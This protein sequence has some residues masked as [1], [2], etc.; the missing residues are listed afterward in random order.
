MDIRDVEDLYPVSYTQQAMLM[1]VENAPES[2]A[3]TGLL[4]C[5]MHAAID[6]AAFGSAWQQVIDKHAILRTS[7]IWKGVEQPIQIVQRRVKGTLDQIDL[8]HLTSHEQATQLDISI[9]EKREK[10]INATAPPLIRLVLFRTGEAAYELAWSYHRLVLDERSLFVILKEVSALYAGIPI[11]HE[12][13]RPYSDYIAWLKQQDSS[14]AGEYWRRVLEGFSSPTALENIAAFANLEKQDDGM[15]EQSLKLSRPASDLLASSARKFR[16]NS[17]TVLQGVWALLL[18]RYSGQRDVIYGATVSTSSTAQ[19]EGPFL[20]GPYSNTLPMRVR[21][22]PEAP[23]LA[24]LKSLQEQQDELRQYSFTSPQKVVPSSRGSHHLPL[25]ESR[26]VLDDFSLNGS[27]QSQ[28]GTLEIRGIRLYEPLASPLTLR[29]IEG[30]EFA[31]QINYDHRR[32]DDVTVSRLLRHLQCL[33]EGLAVQ[34]DANLSALGILREQEVRQVLIDWNNTQRAYTRDASIQHLFEGQV[35]QT[36][37][38]VAL[39]L[40]DQ[41]LSY[42]ELNRRANQLANHLRTLGIGPDVAVG[43]CIGV[44]FEMIISLQAILKAGGAYVP[45]DPSYP[46]DRLAFILDDIQAPVILTEGRFSEELPVG[47]AQVICLDSDWEEMTS[48]SG[49]NLPDRAGADNVAYMMYTSGSTGLPKGVSVIHRG[50]VR[51]IKETNYVDLNAEEVLLQLAPITFDASTFEIWGSLLNGGRLALMPVQLPSLEEIEEAIRRYEVTTMWLTAGLFHL[52]VD[53]RVEVLKPLRQ[54]LAGGDVLSVQHVLKVLQEVPGCRLINGYGPTESTTFTCCYSMAQAADVTSSVPIGRPISNTEVYLL[55]RDFQPAPV[56][57][58]GELFIGGDGLARCYHNRPELTAE[59]FV[60]NPFGEEP[61]ERLYRTGD[62]ARY[63]PD[64]I[65]EFLGRMDNQVKIR[66]FRVEPGE[67][68]AAL[69]GHPALREA[70]VVARQD[71]RG[72]KRLVG[73]FVLHE[74]QECAI[75]E[76]RRYVKERLPDYMVPAAFVKLDALPLNPNGKVDR[77]GLPSPHQELEDSFI[78]PRTLIEEILAEIWI[79]VLGIE[80][81]GIHDSFFDLGGDSIRSIQVRARAQ[82]RGLDFS[83]QQL[84]E[85]QTIYE[86]AQEVRIVDSN[87]LPAQEA[88]PFSLIPEGES[89]QLGY[90]VEDAYPM[91]LLQAG[92]LFHSELSP[93][94]AVYHDIFSF[95]IQ[96]PLDLPSLRASI[97]RLMGEH[98][99]LRT[100]FDQTSFSAPMQ[101][102]HRAVDIPLHVTDLTTL[103]ADEQEEALAQWLT[104]ESNNHFDPSKAPLLRFYAH[105]RSEN[106]F[107]FGVS[108]HH[109]ILDGW[110]FASMMTELFDLYTSLIR[111]ESLPALLPPKATFQQYV[112]LEQAS[113]A[114]QECKLFWSERLSDYVVTKLPRWPS[115]YRIKNDPPVLAQN[116]PISPDISEGLKQLARSAGVPLKS[117]LLACHLRVLSLL[118]GTRDV[119]TGTVTNGRPEGVDGERVLGLFLNTL[120]F[121]LHLPRGS[122]LDLVKETFRAELETIPFRHYPLA[123]IQVNQGRQSLF[124]TAFNF[125][126]FHVYKKI[127][128]SDDLNVIGG[129][130]MGETNLT[131]WA[132]FSLDLVS[133]EV[134]LELTGAAAE[135]S[136]EQLMLIGGYYERA[137]AA[138]AEDPTANYEAVNL[139]SEWERQQVIEE[140]NDTRREFVGEGLGDEFEEQAAGTGDRIAVVYEEE[141]VSYGELN[142]RGNRLGRYLRGMGVVED[143]GVGVCMRRGVEMVAAVV[144]VLKSGGAYVPLD[145]GYPRERLRY[146][147]EDSGA[148]VV[149]S[150]QEE[151]GVL[152][153]VREVRIGEAGVREEIRSQAEWNLGRLGSGESLG[154]IIYTSGSTGRPKGIGLPR[155]ALRNLIGWHYEVL[156]RE[157]RTLQFASLSFDVSFYEIF[158]A[159][160]SGGTVYVVE[161]EVRRDVERLMK[162]VREREVEKVVTPV[163]VLQQMGENYRGQEKEYET[164]K[165]VI[166]TGE[167]LQISRGVREMFREMRGV[168]LQNHYGPSE[169]HVVT[170]EEMS[171]ES[172]GWEVW[173]LIGRP[174]SNSEIYVV[175]GSLREVGIGREG[176]VLIGGEGVARGYI[177]RAEM[178]AEKFIPDGSGKRVG[179]RVYRSGDE[180]RYEGDGKIR[181]LGRR[182]KQVKVR[183]FRVEL[184]EVESVLGEVGGVREAVVEARENGRGEKQ[185]VGYI[186]KG[187]G[188]RTE[189]EIREEMSRKLPDYMVPAVLIEMEKLP[190]TTN[191]KVDRRALPDPEI[192]WRSDTFVSPR[193]AAEK[194]VADVW[195]AVLG[196]ERVGIHDNF[197]VL[198]GHSLVATQVM[199]R[200]RTAFQIDIPL[201]TLFEWP[202]VAGLAQTIEKAIQGGQG[203]SS[204]AV[205]PL[206]LIQP[207][208]TRRPFFCVHPAGGTVF[209]YADLA[210]QLG[211]ERPFYGIQAH[212]FEDQPLPLTRIE[213]MSAE[214]LDCL[215]AAQPEG[216]YFIGGWS[217]GGIVA[218]DMARRLR[219]QG[220]EIKLLALFDTMPPTTA[221]SFVEGEYESLLVEFC[222]DIG[223]DDFMLEWQEL[224]GLKPDQQLALIL[225]RAKKA[226]IVP[227]DVRLSQVWRLFDV[228]KTNVNAMLNYTPQ[229]DYARVTLFRASEGIEQLRQKGVLPVGQHASPLSADSASVIPTRDVDWG[230]NEFVK[231]GPEL[232]IVPGNHYT[233]LKSPHLQTLA[234]KLSQCISEAEDE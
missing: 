135:L 16:L 72:E 127:Q 94:T 182:D 80:R 230:W 217:M 48:C 191:G 162:Y 184:G 218:F 71:E 157:A 130:G 78:A 178:T 120:P 155:K 224:A 181:Y 168:R 214:Y 82:Q 212:I 164:L 145:P 19:A 207:L 15:G 77:L 227:P 147:V 124:E 92:M 74:Q 69:S 226:N 170:W 228:F 86:L 46:L 195:C 171:G 149:I 41:Q 25:Y 133:S 137:L 161:Q 38:A 166:S 200:V 64:G 205:S 197:F 35:E 126:H 104:I 114:S 156:G 23:A 111:N 7:F 85:H 187:G 17:K 3:H 233:M 47:Q 118:S 60:P 121:R 36:P 185:L 231:S 87:T 193:T 222:R 75:D 8:R 30:Q 28:N 31:V 232:H 54:L 221:R 234:E 148:E 12:P 107:Q 81:A 21:I 203:I 68:E 204:T 98:A 108:F 215:L 220:R 90:W 213:E 138:M 199:S 209:C 13:G 91:T 34:P 175:D 176:E 183:G 26:I 208:G 140:W 5:G 83:I 206:V 103:S 112:A 117:V 9:R 57:M 40:G 202:T 42:A 66:G 189:R 223:L 125:T 225:D 4:V 101:L 123:Q 22:I 196:I 18:S 96:S 45:L 229:I 150:D 113:L 76:L 119:L 65:I 129:T 192:N 32:F 14:R 142:R 190:L 61:G 95:H 144:G 173:A 219:E 63:L 106:S 44:S 172:E 79:S 139:L 153:G 89:R 24:W 62:L 194:V 43:V 210:N 134:T 20:I 167:Q 131:F 132:S 1:D 151:E 6:F 186:V 50:V 110:S 201:R 37:E 56:E 70:I 198:G 59:R 122:W 177:R 97:S 188:E 105:Y 52:I 73:Y 53:E 115:S 152:G 136:K 99:V 55:D 160:C 169:T 33:L 88:V 143:D 180:A 93:E 29:V 67:V 158:S 146:M 84:F 154:Y 27:L 179:G 2:S 100:S 216:P 49:E 211:T 10:G 109:A 102:V 174:I 116:V 165:E 39:T 51:L 159:L 11:S 163:T 141:Q 128:E 58:A